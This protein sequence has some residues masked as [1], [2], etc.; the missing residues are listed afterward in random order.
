MA[1]TPAPGFDLGK[2][3]T[4]LFDLSEGVRGAG[5]N[6]GSTAADIADPFRGQR[7][8]YQD[9][10]SKLLT[11]GGA[12]GYSS[13]F[14]EKDFDPGTYHESPGYKFGLQQGL[15]GVNRA[16]NA[17]FGTTRAGNTALQLVDYATGAA[18][19]DYD[20]WRSDATQ[21][22]QIFNNEQDARRS[23]DIQ[24][25]QLFDRKGESIID[26]LLTASG[27]KTGSPAVAAEAYWKGFG[28]DKNSLAS[29]GAG[30]DQIL[31][32]LG[33]GGGALFK[34]LGGINWSNIFGG[35]TQGDLGV[36]SPGGG[37]DDGGL[38]L[39]PPDLPGPADFDIN[40]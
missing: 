2:F 20:K 30:M 36:T 13:S 12:P 14:A 37:V 11:P 6:R 15:E 25:N 5:Q 9:Q 38:D 26:Q 35:P 29:G 40:N 28:Q 34:G 21:N 8:Q 33:M 3:F 24:R 19:A 27:A 16:G 18:Q 22:R 31:N 39:R 32:L 17:M 1:D 4:Q 7:G 23:A 10:L